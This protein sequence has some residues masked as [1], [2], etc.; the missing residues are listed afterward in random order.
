MFSVPPPAISAGWPP[1]RIRLMLTM[2]AVDIVIIYALAVYA[3][4]RLGLS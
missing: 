3:G 2:F 1:P 4:I